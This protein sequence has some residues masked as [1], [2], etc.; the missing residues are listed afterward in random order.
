M[1]HPQHRAQRLQHSRLG[2]PEGHSY[3]G[4]AKL[5]SRSRGKETTVQTSHPEGRVLSEELGLRKMLQSRL[6][7]PCRLLLEDAVQSPPPHPATPRSSWEDN[8]PRQ[9]VWSRAL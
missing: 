9:A 2:A 7:K 3:S 1:T 8:Y 4:E 6:K 5:T